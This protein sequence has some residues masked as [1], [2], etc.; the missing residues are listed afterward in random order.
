MNVSSA[1]AG[2]IPGF[3]MALVWRIKTWYSLFMSIAVR[4]IYGSSVDERI[5]DYGGMRS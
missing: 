4:V 1:D 3:F 5:I 2:A